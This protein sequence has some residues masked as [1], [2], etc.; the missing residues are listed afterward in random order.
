MADLVVIGYPDEP[1]AMS[2]HAKV[3]QLRKD[4]IVDGTAAIVTRT[5]GGRIHVDAPTGA[6]GSAA[7]SGALW[8][9][10]LGLLC[11][12]PIGGP[13]RGGILGALMGRL[14]ASGIDD[15][16]RSRVQQ[17]LKPGGSAVVLAFAK[18]MPD[19]ALAALAPYG[20]EVL[21]TPL[22]GEVEQELRGTLG[23]NEVAGSA[24]R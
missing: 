19:K 18:V 1:T 20:G 3:E 11:F 21:Q 12:V 22:S 2:V 8:G 24:T 14:A 10:L 23:V 7:A 16:F 5:A 4:G 13:V 6:A 17:L 15:A 9:G